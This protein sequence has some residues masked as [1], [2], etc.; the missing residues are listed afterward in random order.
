MK[1]F[2]ALVLVVS[3]ALASL[4]CGLTIDIPVDRVTTG[5]TR[6]EQIEIPPPNAEVIDLTLS[7]GAGKMELEPGA[8]EALVS[9]TARYNVDD[10]KPKITVEGNEVLLDSGSLQIEGLPRINDNIENEWNLELGDQLMNLEIK[11]G[12]Y[13]GDFELG[14]LALKSLRVSDGAADVRLKFSLPNQVEMETLRYQT[15]ASNIHLSGLANAN[16][17]SMLFR[18]GA[19]NYTLDFSGELKRDARVEIESG[20]SQVTLIVPEGVSARVTF[21][22]GLSNVEAS[23]TWQKSGNE[24]V[25]GGSGPMLTINVDMGAGNLVLRNP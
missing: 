12:A 16:F 5:P 9:G 22:G 3:L 4:A 23:G 21:K 6:I 8:Q 10:F 25:L 13:Q 11:A 14:G 2:T 17:A 18:S 1:R 24:Y 20:I 15:G 7:F 19:G